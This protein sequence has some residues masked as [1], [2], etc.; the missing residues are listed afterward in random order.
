MF[1]QLV[2]TFSVVCYW[3]FQYYD[4]LWGRALMH[5]SDV[6]DWTP[7]GDRVSPLSELA[8]HAV[9]RLQRTS[10]WCV[11]SVSCAS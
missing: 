1:N 7:F 8:G 2:R 11:L 3:W 6:V 10:F 5:A 4:Q 9:E